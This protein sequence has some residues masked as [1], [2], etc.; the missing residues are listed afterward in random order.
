MPKSKGLGRDV[1]KSLQ[2]MDKLLEN[3]KNFH[4]A[5]LKRGMKSLK[6]MDNDEVSKIVDKV[7]DAKK[8]A[9][10]LSNMIEDIKIAI[11]GAKNKGNSRFASR[12]VQKFIENRQ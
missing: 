11:K 1:T 10:S 4:S 12:V 2:I 8:E 7:N 9:T 3:L 5:P 6:D